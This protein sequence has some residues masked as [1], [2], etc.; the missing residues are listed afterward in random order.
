MRRP[1]CPHFVDNVSWLSHPHMCPISWLWCPPTVHNSKVGLVGN[2]LNT[3]DEHAVL[4]SIWVIVGQDELGVLG[5]GEVFIFKFLQVDNPPDEQVNRAWPLEILLTNI[6]DIGTMELVWK[7]P[8]LL[9]HI[10]VKEKTCKAVIQVDVEAL[11]SE[12]LPDSLCES[13]NRTG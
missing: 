4:T 9:V 8:V 11:F 6:L 13:M 12:A 1:T 3:R 2:L 7:V 10:R 5:G